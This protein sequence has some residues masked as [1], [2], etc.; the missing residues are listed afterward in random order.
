M[1]ARA[2]FHTPDAPSRD[3]NNSIRALYKSS[4]TTTTAQRYTHVLVDLQTILLMDLH[5]YGPETTTCG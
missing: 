3:P 5:G 4:F 2:R 1:L